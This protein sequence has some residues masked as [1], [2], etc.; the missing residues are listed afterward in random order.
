M[1]IMKKVISLFLIVSLIMTPIQKARAS[2]FG[3]ENITLMKILLENIKQLY[4][5]QQIFKNGQDTLNLM[6]DI[7]YGINDSLKLLDTIAPY[8][9]AGTYKE[10]KKVES[11]ITHLRSIYGTVA[12]SSNAESEK[13]T[14]LVVAEAISLN[15]SLYDYAKD[16]D[17]IGEK[18][19]SY[20]HE[21]SPGGAQKLTAQS[22]G[23]MVHVMNQQLRAQATGLKLQ[24]QS[25]AVQ[26][27]KEKETTSG[28]LNQADILQKAM[29]T[30]Q[31]NFTFPRF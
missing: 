10:F 29:K 16:L 12:K 2:I 9:D 5:L 25:L 30:K 7:N 19:K 20:S 21:V 26:N 14:D 22:L 3:E 18:I 17:Q 13:D 4:E 1:K 28:Y 27:K 8:M 15:N 24:A 23:V 6:R 11:I 31:A